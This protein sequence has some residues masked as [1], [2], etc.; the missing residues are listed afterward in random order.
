MRFCVFGAFVFVSFLISCYKSYFNPARQ[1]RKNGNRKNAVGIVK[2]G[3]N[4]SIGKCNLHT[5]P[6]HALAQKERERETDR[7]TD[8]LERRSSVL[9]MFCLYLSHLR[10]MGLNVLGYY[11]SHLSYY[12]NAA[13]LPSFVRSIRIFPALPGSRLRIFI[14]MQVQHSYNSSTNHIG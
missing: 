10:P 6:E 9:C 12:I 7:R 14:A 11:Q 8:T 2:S 1:T 13:M 5:T 3:L 4:R